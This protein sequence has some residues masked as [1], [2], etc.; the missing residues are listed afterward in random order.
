MFLPDFLAFLVERNRAFD[1]ARNLATKHDHHDQGKAESSDTKADN[2]P[3]LPVRGSK[4]LISPQTNRYD[5]RIINDFL[6]AI[7][8]RDTIGRSVRR[9]SAIRRRLRSAEYGGRKFPCPMRRS[10][11]AF[12]GC[13]S[14]ESHAIGSDKI[15]CRGFAKKGLLLFVEKVTSDA[16]PLIQAERRGFSLHPSFQ[17][18]GRIERASNLLLESRG[19]IRGLGACAIDR[20]LAFV[21]H[22]LGDERANRDDGRNAESGDA[23]FQELTGP[24]P[25]FVA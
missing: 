25:V 18:R 21:K 23:A 10:I 9:I 14:G 13:V 1:A 15:D 20:S 5:Q 3:R 8:S 4:N 24:A 12:R 22:C 19:Q 6:P 2:D 11:D 17:I 7:K 16:L